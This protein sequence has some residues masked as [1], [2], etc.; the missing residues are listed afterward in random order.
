MAH[1]IDLLPSNNYSWRKYVRH[2]IIV[3]SL[4]LRRRGLSSL[5]P[6][7]VLTSLLLAQTMRGIYD[8]ESM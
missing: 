2:P 4:N 3:T 6:T 7:I 1:V 8:Y 5:P